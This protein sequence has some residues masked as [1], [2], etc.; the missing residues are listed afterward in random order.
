LT[1]FIRRYWHWIESFGCSKAK[2]TALIYK[3][4]CKYDLLAE[5]NR[6]RNLYHL[7]VW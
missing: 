2:G 1:I 7:C 6:R 5:T 4:I 3:P